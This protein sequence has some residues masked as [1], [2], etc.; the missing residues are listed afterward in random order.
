MD[1]E[2]K[3][4]LYA[5]FPVI[6]LI[7]Q[8]INIFPRILWKLQH[9]TEF[10]RMSFNALSKHEW[11]KSILIQFLKTHFNIIV[12][13]LHRP[14]EWTLFF[15]LSHQ[16][17]VHNFLHSHAGHIPYPF[18]HCSLIPQYPTSST[19][20]ETTHYPAFSPHLICL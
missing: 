9:I 8:L 7:V 18:C 5:V 6:P 20:Y 10:I 2:T 13:Y 1:H 11:S 12:P 3:H 4:I 17:S 15:P 16:K 19:N 14:S